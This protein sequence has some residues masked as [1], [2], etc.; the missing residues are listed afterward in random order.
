LEESA[1]QLRARH[2]EQNWD[3]WM[4]GRIVQ[5]SRFGS[6]ELTRPSGQSG[7]FFVKT[8]PGGGKV[9]LRVDITEAKR[10][11]AELKASQERYRRL[12]DAIPYPTV[13]LDRVSRRFL[14]ANK[15]TIER[16]GWSHE[17][18]EGMTS[19]D[20]Y[21][22]EDLPK[23]TAM[24]QASGP[25]VARTISGV[26]HRKKDGTLIDVEM[27]AQSMELNG[28]PAILL[29][30]SDVTDRLN[31]ERA[32][33][34]TEEQLRQ[35][36]KM[37]AVGQLTGGIAHDFNNLLT[38]ILA[39]A[40]ALQEEGMDIRQLPQRVQSINE[41]VTRASDL[42]RQLLAFSRKQALDAK[43]TNLNDL[44]ERTGK[45]LRRALGEHIEINSKLAGGL[46]TVK[47]DRTQLETALVNLSVNAR[48]AMPEG[49]K[50]LI[51]TA[52]VSLAAADVRGTPDLAA[53]D[54][55]MLSVTD[56][57]CGISK[58]K[59]TRV[60]EPFFTTKEAGKGT[61]LGLAMVYGFIK[62]SNGHIE[63]E[64]DVGRG[65]TFKLYLPRSDS[66]VQ[67]APVERKEVLPGGDERILVVED[68]PAV[69]TAVV[70]Q[71]QKLGYQ[72]TAAGDG[73]AGLAA[74]GA[75]QAPFDLVLTDV[76]MPG[77]MTGRA[78][79]DEVARRSPAT[80]T[81]FMSGYTDSHLAEGMPLLKKPFRKRELAHFV[82]SS[83]NDRGERKRAA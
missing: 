67:T 56:T 55:V 47:V 3:N 24:R 29:V 62:Q 43:P 21:P 59:I 41:A 80:H 18:L 10:H 58:D 36:Q 22:P 26:R 60:F 15:A 32:R 38:V 17:E 40:D 72:V 48:D 34:A 25:V 52:N 46:W 13:A 74:F 78:L 61:G 2:P 39:N 37:E 6:Y 23:V 82:R 8:M 51:G 69:R 5:T 77:G 19:D 16:Y 4:A 49:G 76:V 20:L 54:Y 70:A 63:V 65:T 9:V 33:A 44:V 1:A 73:Q 71:L 12:F 30:C 45:M 68:E 79:A 83:L 53:G 7:R 11:E 35:S 81:V 66:A 57:G 42:T 64:S 31:G 14:M 50:L 27:Q 75:A 28:Q